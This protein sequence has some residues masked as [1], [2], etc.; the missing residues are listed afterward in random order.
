MKIS[1]INCPKFGEIFIEIK[2]IEELFIEHKNT[3]KDTFDL[4]NEDFR[5]ISDFKRDRGGV[6]IEIKDKRKILGLFT[7]SFVQNNLLELGD[8]IKIEK[9]F[10]RDSYAVAMR[11]SCEFV[12]KDKNKSGIYIYPNKYAIAL[13]KMAGFK[14]HSLYVRNI[15]F[16]FYN[17]I[18][19]LPVQIYGGR[20]HTFFKYNKSNIV[21]KDLCLE[22]TRLNK[23]KLQVFKKSLSQKK[24]SK[25]F[26]LGFLYEF[27]L[28]KQ[29]GD[30]ILVFEDS[31]FKDINIG[32]EFCDNSA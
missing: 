28:S 22:K 26:K 2:E 19:L 6:L 16:V 15:S 17:L 12:I 13:E 8:L 30:P 10:P 31:Q 29:Y 24:S 25:E 4:S 21:R 32:F 20:L 7:L 23:M 5:S 18:F 9:D 14:E 3:F 11:E 1:K 27:N